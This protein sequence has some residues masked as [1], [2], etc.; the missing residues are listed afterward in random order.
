VADEENGDN[1][2]NHKS[3]GDHDRTPGK[4]AGPAPYMTAGAAVAEPSVKF[5]MMS[6]C[7]RGECLRVMLE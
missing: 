1:G 6:L 4:T 7:P 5:S 3:S 2:G